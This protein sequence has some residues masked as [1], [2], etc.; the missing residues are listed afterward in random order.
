MKIIIPSYDRHN[1]MTTIDTLKRHNID[2]AQVYLFLANDEQKELYKPPSE[3]NVVVGV[4]GK[5]NQINFIIDY[6]DEGEILVMIDDDIQDFIILEKPLH[7]ILNEAIEYLKNSQYNLVGFP[8][9]SNKFFNKPRGYKEGLYFCVG[10]FYIMKND[11]AI[12]I[13]NRLHDDLDFTL[14]SYEKYGNVIRC[15]DILFKTKYWGKGGFEKQRNEQ[16][17]SGYY[18]HFVELQYKY[19]KYMVAKTKQTKL[20]KYPIPNFSLK[21]IKDTDVIQLPEIDAELFKPLF[22]ILSR[23]TISMKNEFVSGVRNRGNF[24]EHFPRHRADVYGYVKMRA[25]CWAK[26]GKYNI[27]VISRKRTELYNELKRLGD[28]IVPF[29]YSSILINNNVVCGKHLDA[30][31]IG[32]SLLVSIGEYDGCNIVVNDKKYDAKYKPLIFNGSKLEHYT[33]DDLVGNKY[34]LVFYNVVPDDYDV[35]L[36]PQLSE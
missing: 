12:R 16:G 5:M 24:R 10:A 9:T 35:S 7:Q 34:S 15:F 31:N 21:K 23:T 33:T 1:T 18:K 20:F 32:E 25:N 36:N 30:S 13:T 29:K 6:F 19:S 2:L 27:S 28:I 14:S 3:V 8:P 17:Y 4:L 26:H 22:E 11:K